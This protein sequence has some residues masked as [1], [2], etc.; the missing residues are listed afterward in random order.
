MNINIIFYYQESSLVLVSSL[1]M[2]LIA[3]HLD[4]QRLEYLQHDVPL[5]SRS[6]LAP[7]G[8]KV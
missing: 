3:L 1:V 2:L 6:L 7:N 5:F 8:Y 4:D